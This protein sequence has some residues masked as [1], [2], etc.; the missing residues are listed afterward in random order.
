MRKRCQTGAQGTEP[1]DEVKHASMRPHTSAYVSM[2]QRKRCKPGA[3][4]KGP[5]DEAQP[6]IVLTSPPATAATPAQRLQHRRNSCNTGASP[7]A[8]AATSA[9]PRATAAP[10]P[11]ATAATPAAREQA[12]RLLEARGWERRVIRVRQVYF[13]GREGKKRLYVTSSRGDVGRVEREYQYISPDGKKFASLASAV[14]SAKGMLMYAD[15][16]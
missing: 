5:A 10:S 12:M 14:S 3:T 6:V 16:C 9:S 1:A 2:R 4:G 15:V 13:K 7:P 11:R 8:T